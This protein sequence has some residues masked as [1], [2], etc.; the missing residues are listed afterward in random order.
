MFENVRAD[1]KRGLEINVGP[2]WTGPYRL[3][4]QPTTVVVLNYR[5]GRWAL[6]CPNPVVRQLLLV[7][8]A[9]TRY[10]L[11]IFTELHISLRAQIDPGF[12]VHTAYE[13]FIVH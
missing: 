13:A 3:L 7:V 1:F 2:G 8:T 4:L 5:F 12:D 10:L 9:S 11:E 6:S